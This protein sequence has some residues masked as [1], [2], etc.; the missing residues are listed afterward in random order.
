MG[1]AAGTHRDLQCLRV[2]GRLF[3]LS[4]VFMGNEPFPGILP[5]GP[6]RSPDGRIVEQESFYGNLVSVVRRR[7]AV[8]DEEK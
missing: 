6:N 3:K 2:G 5:G 4:K 1:V 8:P 7:L